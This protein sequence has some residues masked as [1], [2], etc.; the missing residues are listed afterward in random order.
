MD[1]LVRLMLAVVFAMPAVALG[2]Q[3][4]D[5]QPPVPPALHLPLSPRDARF[6]AD[7]RLAGRLALAMQPQRQDE[8]VPIV[9][10]PAQEQLPAAPL[11]IGAYAFVVVMLFGY[12]V[13]VSRR[14]TAI[15]RDVGRLEADVKRSG[16]A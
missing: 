12:L 10:L 8:F 15:Q 11:L 14:L 3:G 9:Q 7:E 4:A 5:V 6:E 2:A 16:K 13:T 1:R